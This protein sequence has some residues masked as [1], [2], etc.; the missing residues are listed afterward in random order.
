MDRYVI[1]F[2]KLIGCTDHTDHR[3][4]LSLSTHHHPSP[5]IVTHHQTSSPITRTPSAAASESPPSSHT[6]PSPH[7]PPDHPP[8][9]LPSRPSRPSRPHSHQST[10]PPTRNDSSTAGRGKD[11]AGRNSSRCRST[12]CLGRMIVTG[13]T[14]HATTL[15]RSL[16]ALPSHPHPCHLHPCPP[17]PCGCSQ[18]RP[19]WSCPCVLCRARGGRTRCRRGF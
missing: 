5:N 4:S 8:S 6:H 17:C 12:V 18:P 9:P 13:E 15:R 3:S 16:L 11:S 1:P 2:L 7:S 14:C 10:S 19:R